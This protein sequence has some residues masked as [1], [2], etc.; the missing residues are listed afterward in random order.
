MPFLFRYTRRSRLLDMIAFAAIVFAVLAILR[1]LPEPA[2][3]TVSGTARILDGDSLIVAGL[4]VC[5]DGVDAPEG[6]QTCTRS[7]ETWSCGRQAARNLGNR[8]RGRIVTCKGHDHDAHGRL[9]AVCESGGQEINRWLVEQGWAV[10]Y[11]SYSDA[12]RRAPGAEG[13][14]RPV[15]RQ[16]HPPARLARGKPL[17]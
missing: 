4:E 10:S 13:A 17:D 9:L 14:A 3:L 5:L 11:G 7:G 1:F 2:A 16:F 15:V 6:A 12:E 8:L